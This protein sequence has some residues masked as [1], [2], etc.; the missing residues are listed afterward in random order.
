MSLSNI[1]K[2]D[3]FL[4]KTKMQYSYH[5]KH[6]RNLGYYGNSTQNQKVFQPIARKVLANCSVNIQFSSE[7]F[8]YSYRKNNRRA[9]FLIVSVVVCIP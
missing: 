8:P 1:L 3:L 6:I 5:N 4:P 9:V 2:I 7:T